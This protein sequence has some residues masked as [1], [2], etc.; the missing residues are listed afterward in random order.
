MFSAKKVANKKIGVY[1]AER[2]LIFLFYTMADD[3]FNEFDE[4]RS[5]APL[6]ANGAGTPSGNTSGNTSSGSSQGSAPQGQNGNFAEEIFS[7]KIEARFR[8]FYIDLKHS[9]NGKFV[10]IS[11]KSKGRKSTVMM[12]AEDLGEFIAA[13]QEV[14]THVE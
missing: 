4:S 9:I 13:L 6:P 11:E 1:N 7:K 2:F 3:F 12:D 14:Q 5:T 8:T 10:K